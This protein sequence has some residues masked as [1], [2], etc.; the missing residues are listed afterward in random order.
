MRLL[1]AMGVPPSRSLQIVDVNQRLLPAALEDAADRFVDIA[2]ENRPDLV[3][4]VA[5]LRVKDTEIRKARTE[6]CH[7]GLFEGG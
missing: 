5:T 4:R 7:G 1:E 3:A 6:Y 2:V